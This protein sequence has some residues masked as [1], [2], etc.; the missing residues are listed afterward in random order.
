MWSEVLNL[1]KTKKNSTN[2]IFYPGPVKK[3]KPVKYFNSLYNSNI[4]FFKSFKFILS[5]IKPEFFDVDFKNKTE[6]SNLNYSKISNYL[7]KS[8]YMFLPHSYRFEGNFLG[9]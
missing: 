3:D 9:I 7:N 6:I 8:E 4:N 1:T 5:N 2:N